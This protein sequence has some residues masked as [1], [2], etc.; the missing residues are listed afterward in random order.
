MIGIGVNILIAHKYK[1]AAFYSINFINE[2]LVSYFL[3]DLNKILAM[4]NGRY[5]KSI[6][7]IIF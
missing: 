4:Y 3:R 7:E 5:C 1:F 6:N 2:S